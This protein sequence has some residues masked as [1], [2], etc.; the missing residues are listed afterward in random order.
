MGTLRGYFAILH[1]SG[2]AVRFVNVYVCTYIYVYMYSKIPLYQ[3]EICNSL[4]KAFDQ[5]IVK[6][7]GKSTKWIVLKFERRRGRTKNTTGDGI[8]RPFVLSLKDRPSARGG[9]NRKGIK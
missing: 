4:L 3:H 2:I 5:S 6:R 1:S 9:G 7:L 8:V